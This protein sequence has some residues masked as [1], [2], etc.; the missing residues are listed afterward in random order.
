VALLIFT[1]G[2]LSALKPDV[3]NIVGNISVL[4]KFQI[5]SL[6]APGLRLCYLISVLSIVPPI[7]KPELCDQAL[8]VSEN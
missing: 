5:A 1:T 3:S 6:P 7:K 8:A 2:F 4:K